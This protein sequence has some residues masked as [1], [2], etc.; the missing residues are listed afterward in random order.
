MTARFTRGQVEVI[1]GLARGRL[2]HEIGADL[3]ISPRTVHGRILRAAAR[4]RIHGRP[5]PQLVDYAYRHGYLTHLTPELRRA[6]VPALT[7][8]LEE[9]LDAT[10]RGL[11][12]NEMA[13]EMEVG[14]DTA[15]TY[16][17]RLYRLLGAST[18]AH[19]VALAWQAGL[20][21]PGPAPR[22]SS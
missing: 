9:A 1:A 21:R 8:R 6:P 22:S 20:R 11:S 3:S 10:A 12:L 19:A 15:N 13:E 14:R 2:A 16:R 7:R 17:R 4:A 5:Q 18:R